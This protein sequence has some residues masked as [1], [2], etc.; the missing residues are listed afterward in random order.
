MAILTEADMR[1]S[2]ERQRGCPDQID[3]ATESAVVTEQIASDPEG[4]AWSPPVR[5]SP[6]T[7]T[8]GFNQEAV[9]KLTLPYLMIRGANDKSVDAKQVQAL[10][11]DLGSKQKVYAELACSSHNAMWEKN[12]LL[13]F[14]ASLDW[15]T[16]GKVQGVSSGTL[17]LGD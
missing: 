12:H 10:Y 1:R 13:L 9:G 6:S 16:T 17:K 14:K 7:P 3:A 4:A 15:L 11:E 5:R 8:W 2:W